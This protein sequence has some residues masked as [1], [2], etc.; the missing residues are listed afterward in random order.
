MAEDASEALGSPE[1]A[2]AFVVPSGVPERTGLAAN[3]L[4]HL[5]SLP[6]GLAALGSEHWRYEGRDYVAVVE[7]LLAAGAEL[8]PRFA[9]V[10]EGPLREWLED[11]S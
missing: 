7:L 2:G 1:V 5:A 4:L 10:A 11:R 8:E 3:A 6:L 9:E